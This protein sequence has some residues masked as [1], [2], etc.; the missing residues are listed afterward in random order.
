MIFADTQSD[1]C[2]CNME[3]ETTIHHFC[4]CSLFSTERIV[5]VDSVF[6]ILASHNLFTD[7]IDNNDLVKIYLYGNS[8]F[9]DDEN[10]GILLATIKFIMDSN[11]FKTKD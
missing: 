1:L 3:A 5:L 6:E 11:R 10:R 9:V 8:K 2:A 7:R 4:S